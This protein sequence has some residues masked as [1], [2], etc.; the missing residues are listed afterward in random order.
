[1]CASCFGAPDVHDDPLAPYR[2]AGS[3]A[4]LTAREI[5][6]A[7]MLGRRYTVKRIAKLLDVT[8]RR[9]YA[10]V[11]VIAVKIGVPDGADDQVTIGD[12]WRMHIRSYS[13]AA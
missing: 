2:A 3:P 1:M 9:V 10:L 6:V 13:A 7:S 8:P 4:G 11:T 5:A 12:W